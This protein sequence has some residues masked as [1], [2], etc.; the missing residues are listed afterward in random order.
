VSLVSGEKQHTPVNPEW[1]LEDQI[2]WAEWNLDLLVSN[3]ARTDSTETLP[4]RKDLEVR[5]LH[6][7][8]G[9]SLRQLARR[10]YGSVDA[11]SISGVRRAIER[12]EKRL[13]GASKFV[14]VS[15]G[16]H[17]TLAWILFGGPPE[18]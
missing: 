18:I 7:R 8:D 15:K 16:T 10:F 17:R 1:P 11:K 14:G 4:N 6:K 2:R 12:V 5:L 3:S 13:H 9:L